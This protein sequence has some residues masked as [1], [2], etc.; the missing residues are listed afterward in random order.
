MPKLRLYLLIITMWALVLPWPATATQPSAIGPDEKIA[1][2]N[3]EPITWADISSELASFHEMNLGKAKA[4]R[5]DYASVLHRIINTRLIL[6]EARNIGLDQLPELKSAVQSYSQQ[7][8]LEML[9]ENYV[10][11]IHVDESEVRQVYE[12]MVREW[13]IKSLRIKKEADAKKIE[14][15]IKAGVNFDQVVEKALQWGVAEADDQGVYVKTNDL[16]MPVAQIIFRMKVGEVSPILAIGKKGF[17][18]F[19]LEE[20]RIPATEDPEIKQVA[21][22][23]ALND[24]RVKSARQYY[25][26]LRKKYAKT[27]KKLLDSLDYQ[28]ATP[29]MQAM[30]KDQRVI[31]EIEGD[32][33]I[34]VADLSQALEKQFYHGIELAIQNKSINRSKEQ[35]FEDLLQKKILRWEALKQGIDK[36]AEYTARVAKYENSALFDVFIKRVIIP[37]IQLDPKELQSYYEKNAEKFSTPPMI[38]IKSLVFDKR[39]NAVGAMEKLRKGTD[40]EWLSANATEQVDKRTKG[41]LNF[42]GQLVTVSSLP[43]KVQELVQGTASGDLRL[44]ESPAGQYYVLSVTQIVKPQKRPFDEVKMDISKEVFDSKVKASIEQWAEKLKAYYPVKIYK[45]EFKQ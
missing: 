29:G 38:R 34:T 10:K 28:A 22:R 14:D 4:G 26:E 12:P 6:L 7:L 20:S 32:T 1:S 43:E 11:D 41:L 31:V 9:L 36:T 24:K 33:P 5:I 25:E 18:I 45:S 40:F 17:V 8:L 42:D 39:D 44:Y 21:T 30:T 13:K 35:V 3:K 23:Q 19:K 15:Q 2:V 16:S 27:D 37:E